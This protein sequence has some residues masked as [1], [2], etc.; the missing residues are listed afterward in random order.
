MRN[1]TPP[2]AA[3]RGDQAIENGA[4]AWVMELEHGAGREPRDTQ[5]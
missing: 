2:M 4:I 1:I 5:P 3:L